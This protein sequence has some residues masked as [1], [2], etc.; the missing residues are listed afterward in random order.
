M[1]TDN[2]ISLTECCELLNREWSYL[3]YYKRA[4]RFVEAVTIAGRDLYDRDKVKKWS[5]DFR[6]IGRP[7]K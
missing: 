6:K 4:G 2:L 7:K 1:E 3:Q 5:P